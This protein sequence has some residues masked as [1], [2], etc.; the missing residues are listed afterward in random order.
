MTDVT[1]CRPGPSGTARAVV[2]RPSRRATPRSV[3]RRR[4]GAL[5]GDRLPL[6]AAYAEL[7]ATDGVRARP[8]RPARGTAD[9]GSAPA[10]LRGCR[11]ADP[12]RR[13]GGRRRVR[14][15]FARYRAGG[16]PSGPHRHPGRAAGTTYRLPV[17]GGGSARAD[18]TSRWSGPGPRSRSP[19]DP[20]LAADV[21]T[22][23]AV[24]PLDRLAAWCLPL[25]RSAA[26]CSRSRARPPSTRSPSIARRSVASAVAS[27]WSRRCGV[28]L[29]DPPTTVVE[30]VRERAV[31]GPARRDGRRATGGRC[32][33]HAPGSPVDGAPGRSETRRGSWPAWCAQA[34]R[35]LRR[36]RR[37]VAPSAARYGSES[38]AALT[39][40]RRIQVFELSDDG[41]RV[42]HPER[43]GRGAPCPAAV[44]WPGV[45]GVAPTV[46]STRRRPAVSC[47][48]RRHVGAR[49][50][51]HLRSDEY[52]GVS[53]ETDPDRR[54]RLR[55][56][57]S[58]GCRQS[59]GEATGYGSQA[60]TG[61][62]LLADAGARRRS[63]S[64][65]RLPGPARTVVTPAPAAG[66]DGC[67]RGG[68]SDVSR[69]TP[70]RGEDDPPLAMEALRAV[71]ILNPSGEITMPRPDHPRVLCV[72]NQKGGVG[73]TTT[74][75]NLA[76]AL[77]LHGNRVLVVDLDPQGNASTG[78]NVPH[79]AGIPDVYDCLIDNV[80]L[81]EVVQA[82]RGHPEPLVRA[83][84][85]RPGRR[86]DRAGLRG[87]PG[88]PAGAG[89]RR[90]PGD[91]RL[92]LHRLP[93]VPRPADGQR[94]R[95]PRRRC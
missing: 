7:L 39:L 59:T 83:G 56:R 77:A 40:V 15:R 28:G 41:P 31:R 10:Q 17:R 66:A 85:H 82:G 64:R 87:R 3:R 89:H 71:Q 52:A 2:V 81:A 45:D 18:R 26:G 70:T 47:R 61:A 91:V 49:A 72:A 65:H 23:R 90:A 50:R 62:G 46:G 19:V 36:P 20:P 33:S 44:G 48:S 21:V 30:I 1:P 69:E 38:G 32:G 76:V 84:D 6:A 94:A 75:V 5:F 29:I 16:G 54:G 73:K 92:R 57:M 88:V 80:P 14:C 25:A 22:A 60:S 34:V 43:T 74:A 8:D 63:R 78:L 13:F 58:T 42:N 37:I 79:H 12:S 9:L 53:R 27:R 68:C 86:R 24:A 95:A 51:V 67:G 11:R 35:D 93:A 4:R 55:Q